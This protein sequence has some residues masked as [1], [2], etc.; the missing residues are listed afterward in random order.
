MYYKLTED[1]CN[2]T[3]QCGKNLYEIYP[4]GENL[5]ILEPTK[6]RHVQFRIENI[7]YTKDNYI[8]AGEELRVIYKKVYGL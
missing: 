5:K 6:D 1:I 7:F 4:H 3:V 2:V 8:N